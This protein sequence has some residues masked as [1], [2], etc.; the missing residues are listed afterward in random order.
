MGDSLLALVIWERK[1]K[2]RLLLLCLSGFMTFTVRAQVADT[3]ST[4]ALN[5]VV[6]TAERVSS[7]VFEHGAVTQARCR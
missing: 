5:P 3:D 2:L 1:V 7:R 6:V 4:I